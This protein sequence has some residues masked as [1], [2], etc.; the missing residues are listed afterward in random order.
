[1]AAR[2]GAERKPVDLIPKA[3]QSSPSGERGFASFMHVLAAT[4]GSTQQCAQRQSEFRIL[5][6]LTMEIVVEDRPIRI[7]ARPSVYE[8]MRH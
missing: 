7:A 2:G 5:P 8:Q 6:D 3:R 4:L 1:M